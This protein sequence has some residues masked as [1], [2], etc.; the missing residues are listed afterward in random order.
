MPL[1]NE[2][3]RTPR[4]DLTGQHPPPKP[5]PR[6]RY[7]PKIASKTRKLELAAPPDEWRIC[8]SP[9][10][11]HHGILT[12]PSRP[13]GTQICERPGASSTGRRLPWCTTDWVVQR[14]KGGEVSPN[15]MPNSTFAF[16]G[17]RNAASPSPVGVFRNADGL[18]TSLPPDGRTA[19]DLPALDRGRSGR[20]LGHRRVTIA[21][22]RSPAPDR[23]HHYHGGRDTVAP[24]LITAC[25]QAT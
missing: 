24:R 3:F 17:T 12:C 14:P 4:T 16:L 25:A 19:V 21:A 8:R 1:P 9:R 7:T 6:N 22:L 2:P 10:P 5:P 23:A 15:F 13:V 20:R 18:R 11:C